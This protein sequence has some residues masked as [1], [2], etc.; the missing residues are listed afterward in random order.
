MKLKQTVSTLALTGMVVASSSSMVFADQTNVITIGANL[1]PQQKE[2]MLKFFNASKGSY[3]EITINNQEEREALKGIAPLSQIGTRT[4]SCAYV[5]PGE[6]NTGINVKTAN[7]TWVTASM[8]SNALV[9]AGMTDAN[10]IAAA[11]F[12]V[13]GTGALTGVMKAF[14]D[15]TGKQLDPAK[16]ELANKELVATGDIAKNEG[17]GQDKAAAAVNDVKT[18]V[19]KNGT[20]DTNQIADTINNVMNNY[21]INLSPEQQK[22]LQAT[23]SGIAD[24]NYDYKEMKNT[25]NKVGTNI[26]GSLEQTGQAI[27]D[28][29][30]FQNLWSS[31]TGFFASDNQNQSTDT[32]I[33]NQT[34]NAA[35]G[36]NAQITDTDSN[37]DDTK[38]PQAPTSKDSVENKS[39][40]PGIFEKIKNWFEGLFADENRTPSANPTEENNNQ[41]I[42]I[43]P[44]GVKPNSEDGHDN[45]NQPTKEQIQQNSDDKSES[46]LQQPNNQDTTNS[47]NA[48]LNNQGN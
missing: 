23:M 22:Q 25:L 9:T 14:E 37:T 30:F 16:K 38:L 15:A 13:S 32:G 46:N 43:T 39:D 12:K 35:L 27:K 17:V 19:I 26:Q 11:P 42:T 36:E 18:Q 1:T 24:Q 6:Q 21:N 7:L 2:D 44:D 20:K 3:E 8:I 40:E 47:D 4:L 28:S 41:G 10:V 33:L 31:I 29:G 48:V 5:Q 45:S 34:N